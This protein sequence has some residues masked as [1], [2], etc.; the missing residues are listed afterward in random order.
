MFFSARPAKPLSALIVLELLMLGGQGFMSDLVSYSPNLCD[1][2]NDSTIGVTLMWSLGAPKGT[3]LCLCPLLSI[4]KAF[5]AAI[6][7][8]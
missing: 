5:H 3:L 8:D 7:S 2:Q 1:I 6:L 4:T